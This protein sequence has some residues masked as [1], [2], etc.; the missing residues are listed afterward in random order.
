MKKIQNNLSI[1]ENVTNIVLPKKVQERLMEKMMNKHEDKIFD[2][3]QIRNEY[4]KKIKDIDLEI[5]NLTNIY[6][7]N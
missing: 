6:A 4:L 5:K 7:E 1:S 2:M 3:L